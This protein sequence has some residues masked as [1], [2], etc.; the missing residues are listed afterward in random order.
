MNPTTCDSPVRR[1][2]VALIPDVDEYV[3]GLRDAGES[4][5]AIEKHLRQ[6]TGGVLDV[7]YETLRRWYER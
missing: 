1:L 5:R 4:W 7:S 3:L 6:L 2:A